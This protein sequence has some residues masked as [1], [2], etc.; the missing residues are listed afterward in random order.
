[1]VY[2]AEH[3]P[4]RRQFYNPRRSIPTGAI[5]LHTAEN[6]PDFSPPDDGAEAVA[7]FIQ[8][9]SEAGSYHT[10]VD[11]DGA[12]QLGE[13]TWEMFGEGTGGNRWALHLAAACRTIDW[14]TDATWVR[15]T[16]SAMAIE[17]QAM[18]AWC[19]DVH[20]I[21]V[22]AQYISAAQYRAGRPGFISH[23]ELDPRRRHDPGDGSPGYGTFPWDEFMSLYSQ[24]DTPMGSP[25]VAAMQEILNGAGLDPPLLVDG[26]AGPKTVEGLRGVIGYQ[27]WRMVTMSDALTDIS[28]K[29]NAALNPPAA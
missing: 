7:R 23:S 24:G 17:A 10:V 16:L 22:P 28:S 13:Y 18:A 26:V 29:A 11:S 15:D 12:I 21:E 25:Y 3:P 4:V 2:L 20:G 14:A 27:Q 9:R 5:V 8:G 1:M 6:M 19:K